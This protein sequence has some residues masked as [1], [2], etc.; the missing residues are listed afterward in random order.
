M[1]VGV[2]RV[3]LRLHDVHSLKDKRSIIKKLINRTGNRFN[4]SVS[5]TALNDH[6]DLAEIGIALS[7]NDPAHVNSTLDRIINFMEEMYLAEISDTDIEVIS[8]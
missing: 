8:F 2:C 4:A 6:I 1:V 5:E 3:S 7:G